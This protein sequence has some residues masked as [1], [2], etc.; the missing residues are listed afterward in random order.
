MFGEDL[1]PSWYNG[2]LLQLAHDL[3]SRL[4]PAFQ[5]SI[6]GIPYP[7]VSNVFKRTPCPG[8]QKAINNLIFSLAKYVQVNLRKGTVDEGGDT[9]TAG[10]GSLLLE[11]GALSRLLGD[12]IYESMARR[13]NR[14]LWSARAK[15]TGLLGK[16]LCRILH[17]RNKLDHCVTC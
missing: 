7:R 12:P 13:A 17:Y 9:C 14:A 8:S 3:A 10:A 16:I 4:L 1:R 6:T 15:T 5:K 11:F 2:Q